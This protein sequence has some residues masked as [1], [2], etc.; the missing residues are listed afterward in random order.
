ML[1]CISGQSGSGKTTTACIVADS[2]NL[3][4][5]HLDNIGE[6]V[7]QQAD[8]KGI[9]T[10]R[11]GESI[12]D[13]SGKIDI[14]KLG[15]IIF[16]KDADAHRDFHNSVVMP[17]VIKIVDSEIEKHNGNII[18]DFKLLPAMKYWE[19]A[20][21]RIHLKSQAEMRLARMAADDKTDCAY[22][23]NRDAAAPVITLTPPKIDYLIVNEGTKQQLTEL[24]HA[25]IAKIKAK[26]IGTSNG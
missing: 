6:L 21:F 16:A 18:L 24:V 5:L 26:Q 17:E 15:E 4:V 13:D 22:L 19:M 12:L 7:W 2:L 20:D 8:I 14:K 10:A 25:G 3:P 11:F 1:I 23:L 9:L